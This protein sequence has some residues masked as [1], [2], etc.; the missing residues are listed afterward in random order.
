MKIT[1]QS[2]L[3][4]QFCI[5]LAFMM[6]L[7]FIP[8]TAA[9][10][11][12]ANVSEESRSRIEEVREIL[13]SIPYHEY[14]VVHENS[15]L[16]T[17]EISVTQIDNENTTAQGAGTQTAEGISAFY[18]PDEGIVSFRFN[19]PSDGLYNLALTYMQVVGKTSGIER[20]I[21]IDGK[22]PFKEA[23]YITLSKVYVD[24][25]EYD[26]DGSPVFSRDIK[27]NEI[28][29]AK[30]ESPEWR[31]ALAEDSS[32]FIEEPFMFYL[33][34]GEHTISFEAVREPIYLS[35]IKFIAPE[36]LP[37]YEQYLAS[38]AD[39]QN[40]TAEIDNVQAEKP[41]A[42]SEIVI[43]PVNDRTS[44]LTYPQNASRIRLNSIGGTKWQMYG[45]WLR[46]E[47]EVPAGGAG[48]YQIVPRYKQST[49]SGVYS[50]RKIKIDGGM[51]FV[52]ANKLR[53]NFSDAWQ[54]QPL[55]DGETEFEFYFSEGK[56]VL[57]FEVSLGAM[58]EMLGRVEESL[59]KM[60]EMYRSLRMVTGATPDANRDYGFERTHGQTVLEP[61]RDE[62]INLRNI[63]AELE[64]IIGSKGE[65][66]VILDR[67]ALQMERMANN[68]DRIASGLDTFKTNIGSLG[69]WLLERRNQPLELDYIN[70]HRIDDKLP[71]KEANFIQSVGFEFMSFVMSF[72]SDYNTVGVMQETSGKGESV[73]VWLGSAQLTY[74]GL[75]MAGRDQAQILRQ[76]AIDFT[77]Q[78][79]I[80]TNIKLVAGGS[81]LP[82]VLAGVGPDVALYNNGGDAVN[83]AIR[84]A[85][86]PLNDFQA[87]PSRGVKSFEEVQTYFHPSAFIP[88]TLHDD[89]HNDPNE[90]DFYGKPLQIYGLPENQTFPMMFYRKDILVDLDIEIPNT[91]QDLYNIIPELQKKNLEVGIGPGM[92][93]LQM[94]MYQN[95]V[96]LYKGDGIEVNLDDNL[97]L[98]A[99]KQMTQL[100][101]IYKFPIIFDFQNRFRSGEMPIGIAGYDTY[102][103][104]TVFAPEI[105]GLWEFVPLPGTVREKTPEDEGKGYEE[106][107][108]GLIIDRDSPAGVSA[109]LM[110]RSADQRNNMENAWAFMQWW[111]SAEQ[112][113]RFGNEIIAIMGAAAKQP[114]AN[115]EALEGMAWPASDYKNLSE[116]FKYLAARPEVPGGYIVDRHVDFAWK[117]VYNK[118]DSPVERMLDELVEINKELS[119]KRQEFEM[120]VVERDKFGRKVE[121]ETNND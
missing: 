4:K 29:P 112:Q 72:F 97:A 101:T 39:K 42:V 103:N 73:E 110:M 89:R 19:V 51:P 104:L 106:L 77:A 52:E 50:S 87:D 74:G 37:T 81:L 54:V 64:A 18:L 67:V 105:R 75:A 40:G 53:F 69:T 108:G 48:M 96:P 57:E 59:T 62:A 22:V 66:S 102:N 61:M 78:T 25:Y 26:D 16:G 58:G 15:P 31:K 71:Q 35:E 9:P 79:G 20:M 121:K 7:T 14:V 47:F 111:V 65:H 120:P 32:G 33:S 83:Y 28:R 34:A 84:G 17:G 92:M 107:E 116:Q 41:T 76:L 119:R 1:K 43:Y 46:Y 27:D 85:V 3:R 11:A 109:T 82:S 95:N 10:A 94:F 45:Q 80:Q 36:S 55:S 2:K 88:L 24:L 114:T 99:F 118:G 117:G 21:R 93:P 113:S 6:L 13:D 49:Y 38:H 30:E 5:F 115:R 68:V 100:Y 63:S 8:I 56:H 60:N 44:A 90:P 12:A 70:I 86:Q 91:W 98:D 23:R